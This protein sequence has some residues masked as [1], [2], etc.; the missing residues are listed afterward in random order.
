MTI[1]SA[2]RRRHAGAVVP[3]AALVAAA[4]LL[5][6]AALV[7]VVATAP[8]LAV[9]VAEDARTHRLPN[10]L[11]AWAAGLFVVA[12][13]VVAMTDHTPAA[14]AADVAAGAG[15]LLAVT[16]LLAVVAGLGMGDVKLAGLLGT[17]VGWATA[18]A[19]RSAVAA[20]AG[21]LA[22]LAAASLSALPATRRS[23]EAVPFGPNLVAAAALVVAVTA[24]VA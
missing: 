20:A 10:R 14:V 8:A 5:G 16:G 11:L 12:A 6:I 1:V 23:P 24:I 4:S 7:P 2:P 13:S 15:C 9:A 19:G 21:A 3:I 17:V 22:V 18:M